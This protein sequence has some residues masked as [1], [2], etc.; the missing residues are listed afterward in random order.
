MKALPV[1]SL[2]GSP[3]SALLLAADGWM[4]L[5]CL[6]LEPVIVLPRSLYNIKRWRPWS[7]RR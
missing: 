4:G 3:I 7:Q 5:L 6:P 1:S 2:I